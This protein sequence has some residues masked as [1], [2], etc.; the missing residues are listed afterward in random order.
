[1]DAITNLCD[2][3]GKQALGV[4]SYYVDT[5]LHAAVCCV[6]VHPNNHLHC[7]FPTGHHLQ[8]GDAITIHLDNRTGVSEYDAELSVYRASY[9]GQVLRVYHDMV[10]V[11][12]RECMV[13]F[14][15]KT[16]LGIQ[17]ADYAYPHDSRPLQAI[18]ASPLTAVPPMD[19]TERM[20]KVGVLITRAPQQPHSTV[21]AFLS[22][23]HDDIFFITFDESFKMAVLQ[24]DQRCLFAIDS[25]AD[26]TFVNAIQWNYSLIHGHVHHIA[27]SSP[28]F[29][30][31]KELFIA[32]NPWEVGFF[33]H[34]SVQLYHIQPVASV[35]AS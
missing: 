27:R 7:S 22:S 16:V 15:N 19:D 4:A 8:P 6:F 20:N 31:I 30:P 17:A 24:R 23:I 26:F 25:R 21:M 32:K 2:A 12:P 13:M 11:A 28:L 10:E 5:R 18:P 35:S 34:P 14:G 29:N 33:D 3:I 1:M 9:K